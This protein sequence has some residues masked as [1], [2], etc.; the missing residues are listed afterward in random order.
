MDKPAAGKLYSKVEL[1]VQLMAKKFLYLVTFS[2]VAVLAGLIVLRFWANELSRLAFVPNQPFTERPSLG[3]SAYSAPDLWFVSPDNQRDE[4]VRWVQKVRGE[5]SL[6]GI[7]AENTPDVYAVF[8]VHPTSYLDRNDWNA[9]FDNRK[10]SQL[11]EQWIRMMAS[12]FGRAKEI[13]IPRYRQATYGAFLSDSLD[14]KL[15]IALAYSDVTSAFEHFVQEIDPNIPF[16]LVGHS[17]GAMHAMHLIRD[18]ITSTQLKDRLAAAY[19]IGWPISQTHD[20]PE[21]R[22]PSCTQAQ[23]YGC[24]QSWNSFAEP[25]ETAQFF[26]LYRQFEGLDGE[27]R[28]GSPIVCTN[29]ISGIVGGEVFSSDNLGTLLST[30]DFQNAE[31]VVGV[32]PARCDQSGVL[33]IGDPP[34]I[35]EY[36]LPGNDYHIYDIPLFWANIQL[37][38]GNRVNAWLTKR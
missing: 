27:L 12:P 20:V 2:I 23:Q 11:A 29:P 8:F 5:T 1:A 26:S 36:V 18:R 35:G 22:M 14:A 3:V 10:A 31:L 33:L 21:L 17:Q 9:D 15:A 16:V 4:L 28:E 7:G 34:D 30:N 19:L 37:D 32:V 38:V 6:A 13:W 25:H 24:I